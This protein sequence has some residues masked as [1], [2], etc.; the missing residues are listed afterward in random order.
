[1]SGFEL[2]YP[3]APQPERIT[4]S[5]ESE[6]LAEKVAVYV[7]IACRAERA[8]AELDAARHAAGVDPGANG[9][10]LAAAREVARVRRWELAVQR[11][12][13][14]LRHVSAVDAAAGGPTRGR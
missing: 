5:V 6:L 10:R 2:L 11:E 12:A 7:R 8:E 3:E 14:G 4:T 1:M 9:C 13:L